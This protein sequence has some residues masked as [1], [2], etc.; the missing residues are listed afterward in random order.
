MAF[1]YFP[2]PPKKFRQGRS[3]CKV[4][5]LFSKR[6]NKGVL[7]EERRRMQKEKILVI[8]DEEFI[9]AACAGYP[10]KGGP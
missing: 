7:G 1:F 3:P 5:I 8:D 10:D 2:S 4:N 9:L 6:Y